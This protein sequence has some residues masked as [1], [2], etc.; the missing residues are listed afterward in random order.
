[1]GGL[2]LIFR[3]EVP[4]QKPPWAISIHLKSEGQ[5]GKIGLFQG[6]IPVGGGGYKKRVTKGEC[7]WCVLYL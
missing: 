2:N 7:G 4:W 6:W 3:P 5:E 1:M